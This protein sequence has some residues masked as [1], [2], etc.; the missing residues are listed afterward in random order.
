MQFYFKQDYRDDEPS[1]KVLEFLRRFGKETISFLFWS[2]YLF[3]VFIHVYL[4]KQDKTQQ[5]Q[6]I[7]SIKLKF[8]LFKH[9][10]NFAHDLQ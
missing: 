10:C 1:E 9:H 5:N 6:S 8:A 3:V 2:K 4:N 7:F